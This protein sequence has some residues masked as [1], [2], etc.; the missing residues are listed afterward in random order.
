MSYPRYDVQVNYDSK[1]GSVEIYVFRGGWRRVVLKDGLRIVGGLEGS[2]IGVVRDLVRE[3]EAIIG[4][5]KH[6]DLPL[7]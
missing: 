1:R 2:E 4:R 3:L 5:G 6:A 7:L